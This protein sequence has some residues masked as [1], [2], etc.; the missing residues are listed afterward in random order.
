MKE[1]KLES[2]VLASADKGRDG[3]RKVPDTAAG[4][5]TGTAAAAGL[6]SLALAGD[7]ASTVAVSKLDMVASL[8]D[9]D[10]SCF[11]VLEGCCCLCQQIPT[12]CQPAGSVQVLLIE[13][14][15][16]ISKVLSSEYLASAV[17]A[18][19][20]LYAPRQQLAAGNLL[21][22]GRAL[23]LWAAA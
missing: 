14:L 17:E 18:A 7:A 23:E 13:R 21:Q 15:V 20:C 10:S 3:S 4:T 22:V 2:L 5:R 16:L 12:V 6:D 1:R 8:L 19:A 9:A 11:A